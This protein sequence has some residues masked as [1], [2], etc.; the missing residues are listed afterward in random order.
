[1]VSCSAAMLRHSRK[2]VTCAQK[3]KTSMGRGSC[4]GRYATPLGLHRHRSY[5]D[6]VDHVSVNGRDHTSFVA[7]RT[8]V[9]K[10][11]ITSL[12]VQLCVVLDSRS[13]LLQVSC[14]GSYMYYILYISYYII[15]IIHCILY[16]IYYILYYILDIRYYIL[17][18]TYCIVYIIYYVL[19]IILQYTLY[20]IYYTLYV[21]YYILYN[22]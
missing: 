8:M 4:I 12:T 6:Y 16:I 10:R 11:Q 3:C 19:Y 2:T 21:T 7:G 5:R 14:R 1:M 22:M 15:Y 20:I 18:L 17:H 13:C 9:T